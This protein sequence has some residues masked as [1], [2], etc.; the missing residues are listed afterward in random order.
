MEE[1]LEEIF[2]NKLELEFQFYES[3]INVRRKG[4]G[5]INLE[6]QLEDF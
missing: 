4:E 2:K 6:K 3:N 5:D 1:E